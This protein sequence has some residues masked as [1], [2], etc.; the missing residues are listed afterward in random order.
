MSIGSNDLVMYLLAVDRAN[1]QVEA[2]YEPH[3]PAVFRALARV[4]DSAKRHDTPIS[5]CG[6]AGADPAMIRF[7]I[8]CG[9]RSISADPARISAIRS[10]VATISSADAEDFARRLTALPTVDAVAACIAERP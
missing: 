7:L 8:G 3:H 4:I 5:I 10:S 2:L 6:E 1:E 9:L